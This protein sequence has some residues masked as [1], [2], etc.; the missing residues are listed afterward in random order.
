[1]ATDG[2]A[3]TRLTTY[4]IATRRF[5]K[6]Q[7]T[8]IQVFTG[9]DHRDRAGRLYQAAFDWDHNCHLAVITPGRERA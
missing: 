6:H 1:M 8:E 5:T 2:D 7:D 4:R 3:A 9:S